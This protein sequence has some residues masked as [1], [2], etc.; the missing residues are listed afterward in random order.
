MVASLRK[1]TC[2]GKISRSSGK[3]TKDYPKGAIRTVKSYP[4]EDKNIKY[5]VPAEYIYG[6][7]AKKEDQGVGRTRKREKIRGKAG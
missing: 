3:I 7:A 4:F 6:G 2:I 1:P 5:K